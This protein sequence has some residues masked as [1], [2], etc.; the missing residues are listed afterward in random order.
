MVAFGGYR[1]GR[2]VFCFCAS[3]LFP[4]DP[5]F[6]RPLFSLHHQASKG[7]VLHIA[8]LP[9]EVM[10]PKTSLF[11]PTDFPGAHVS[12]LFSLFPC[13]GWDALSGS[14]VHGLCCQ[15]QVWPLESLL[16]PGFCYF[17]MF[18]SLSV[19]DW[20]FLVQPISWFC[21]RQSR[22]CGCA[23]SSW[24][25]NVVI[26]SGENL[27]SLLFILQNFCGNSHVLFH[28][29]FKIIASVSTKNSAGIWIEILYVN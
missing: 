8:L 11:S 26:S 29:R 25:Y 22:L 6:L 24:F 1:G 10:S 7:H 17:P 20:K 21:S 9:P 19:H 12:D 18:V 16:W 3:L 5:S 23:A 28:K 14:D 13:T 15:N 4:K 27:P 2:G